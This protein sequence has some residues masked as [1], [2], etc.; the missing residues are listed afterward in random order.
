[1]RALENS[2]SHNIMQRKSQKEAP[3]VCFH[4]L[5]IDC[6]ELW[7]QGLVHYRNCI[8]F[9]LELSSMRIHHKI[10]DTMHPTPVTNI[11]CIFNPRPHE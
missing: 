9:L 4:C 10:V 6:Y 1:M 5:V 11:L 3:L 8:P 2:S 7:T